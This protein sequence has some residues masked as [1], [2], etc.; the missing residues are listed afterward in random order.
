MSQ[1]D[2]EDN[3][4]KSTDLDLSQTRECMKA[5]RD[6]SKTAYDYIIIRKDGKKYKILIGEFANEQALIKYKKK[7]ETKRFKA[8]TERNKRKKMA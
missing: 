2:E 1:K 3:I 4:L 8:R 5:V 6:P 7:V